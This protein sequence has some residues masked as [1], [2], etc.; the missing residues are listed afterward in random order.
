[1]KVAKVELSRASGG[2]SAR[3]QKVGGGGNRHCPAQGRRCGKHLKPLS[4]LC[5]PSSHD[6]AAVRA[7][8]GEHGQAQAGH[9]QNR[10]PLHAFD[11]LWSLLHGV[12]QQPRPNT[13]PFS[14]KKKHN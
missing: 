14:S 8:R 2:P 12:V 9:V 4:A 7:G 5:L 1:M 10:C 3:S 6:G 11:H 13:T